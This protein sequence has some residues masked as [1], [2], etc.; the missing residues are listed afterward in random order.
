MTSEGSEE[1]FEGDI[2][3]TGANKCPLMSIEGLAEGL[4]TVLVIY[5]LKFSFRKK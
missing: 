5:F 2:A 1:V 3:D 4:Q